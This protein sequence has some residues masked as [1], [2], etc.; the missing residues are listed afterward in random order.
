MRNFFR[1]VSE[2]KEVKD[3]RE[4]RGIEKLRGSNIW[5]MNEIFGGEE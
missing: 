2:K 1:I 5:L 4:N 3:V